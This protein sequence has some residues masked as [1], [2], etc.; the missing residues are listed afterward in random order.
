[1]GVV[2]VGAPAA[3]VVEAPVAAV[4]SVAD[5]DRIVAAQGLLD[6]AEK[7]GGPPEAAEGWT[8]AVP[9]PLLVLEPVQA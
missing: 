1:V 5:P 3:A 6:P 9:T 7:V 8:A 4:G 2:V